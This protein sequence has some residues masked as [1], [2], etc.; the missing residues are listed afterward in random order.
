MSREIES[1]APGRTRR[2]LMQLAQ[3]GDRE[4]FNAL[5]NDIGPEIM[6]FLRRRIV[7]RS[8]LEDTCQETLLAI[9]QSRHTYQP[10]RPVEPW[11]FAIARYVGARHFKT[12]RARNQFQELS[13]ETSQQ[14]GSSNHGLEIEARQ[15]LGALPD[16]QREAFTMLNI[17]GLSLAEASTR[18]GAS[19]G[20][21]KVRA[22][23]A[24][25]RLKRL[26]LA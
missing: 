17:E 21:I 1:A 16:K 26:M 20:T 14:G 24:Y 5:V 8:E 3:A 19:I 9:Y 4:A 2:E 12:T 6:R 7:D 10:G 13:V 18:T 11:V 22:H 25:E 15:A 23:R